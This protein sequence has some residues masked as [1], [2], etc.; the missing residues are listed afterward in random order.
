ML[1]STAQIQFAVAQK[2]PV[3]RDHRGQPQQLPPPTQSSGFGVT[4]KPGLRES[5]LAK[6]RM[7]ELHAEPPKFEEGQRLLN[8]KL[9]YQCEVPGS[10]CSARHDVI[11]VRWT[12]ITP[13][14]ELNFNHNYG[15]NNS[16][17]VL[18]GAIHHNCGRTIIQ[19]YPHAACLLGSAFGGVVGAEGTFTVILSLK[20]VDGR[21]DMTDP[22]TV[23]QEF[24]VVMTQPRPKLTIGGPRVR[25]HR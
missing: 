1:A 16:G 20:S 23:V 15:L 6:F 9:V 24:L 17:Q 4:P 2:G 12:I 10:P 22:D 19:K 25:D 18:Y 8:F 3:V 5:K 14:P 13:K 21:P 11:N 7:L